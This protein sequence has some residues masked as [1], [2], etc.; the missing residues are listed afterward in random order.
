MRCGDAG[1]ML[2]S[3]GWNLGKGVQCVCRGDGIGRG[4]PARVAAETVLD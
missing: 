1:Y 3:R 4:V 2:P